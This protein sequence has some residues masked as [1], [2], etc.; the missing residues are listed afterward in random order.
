M[1]TAHSRNTTQLRIALRA[2]TG[3]AAFCLAAAAIAGVASDV[4]AAARAAVQ[5]GQGT[6]SKGSGSQGSPKAPASAPSKSSPAK[7]S[8]TQGKKASAKPETDSKGKAPAAAAPAEKLKTVYVVPFKGQF[9]TDIHPACY[10]EILKDL[11]AKR[12]DIIVF[13]LDSADIDR[14][15]YM[16]E[17][18]RNA[19]VF[20]AAS[21]D[22]MMRKLLRDFKDKHGYAQQYMWVKDSVGYGSLL[23]FSWPNMYMAPN[24]RLFGLSRVASFWTRIDDPE[25]RAKFREAAVAI[26]NGFL[27]S[28]GYDLKIGE[29]ML[30]PDMLLSASYKGRNIEWRD[31][32]KGQWLVDGRD[33][34]TAGFNA[35][36][37][38]ELGLSKGSA[39]SLD[40]LMFVLGTREFERVPED[41]EKL[42]KK[43][44]D[45]WRKAYDQCTK[46][47]EE[48]NVAQE[49]AQSANPKGNLNKAK[50]ALT[51]VLGLMKKYPPLEVRL[52]GDGIST[53]AVETEILRL[54]EQIR[55][56]SQ[57]QQDQGAS[58][59]SRGNRGFGG[60]GRGLSR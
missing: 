19:G 7:G 52:Q 12:P 47:I 27:S 15:E 20:S 6:G 30:R 37:A 16:G 4:P 5:S 25:V 22:T 24:A 59:G 32:A 1:R 3:T 42:H 51:R 18:P 13:E 26:I 10:E 38:E 48:S 39:D 55:G 46:L 31:D 36:S 35:E 41:G 56:L 50:S 45:D 14:V 17:D 44:V 49:D 54:N 2:L 11:E 23:A 58:G 29:A 33:D 28:G 57:S 53:L 60:G 21:D 43:Y 34:S 8:S 9:G 40:E